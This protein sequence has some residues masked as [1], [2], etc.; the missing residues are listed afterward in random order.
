MRGIAKQQKKQRGQR[1]GR[2]ARG[3][4]RRSDGLRRRGEPRPPQIDIDQVDPSE[5]ATLP[6]FAVNVLSQLHDQ[7]A[8]IQGI[9]LP[10]LDP[11]LQRR[12]LIMVQSHLR[13][14]P[15]LAAGVASL[16]SISQAFA[17]TQATWRFL[18]NE[19]VG[20]TDL[21]EPLREVGRS[22]VG[23]L[24]SRFALLVHDWCK[25]TFTYG[26]R[27]MTQLTHATDVGYELTTA[28]LVSA[29]DGSPLAPMEMHLK[30][31]D[32]VISTRDPTPRD[33]PHLDQVLPTMEASRKWNLDKSLLHVI[34]READSVDYFRKWDAEGFKFLVRADDRRVRWSGKSLL[35]SEIGRSLALG[36]AFSK[37]TDEASYQGRAAELWVA[38]T[39]VVLDRPARK[40][41]KGKRFQVAGRPL[42]LRYIVVQL[43][44]W[45]GK[46][47]AQ[48]MLLTNASKSVHAEHLARCYYWRWRIESFFKLLK[49]HGQQLEQWQ[50]ETGA[51][52]A[53]RLLVAAMA[54]VVVWQLQ[55]DDTPQA[56]ELKAILIRLSGRQMKGNRPHTAPALL[57]GLWVLLSMLALLEHYDLDDLRR[58]AAIIP[59]FR[60]T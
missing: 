49:S 25:L 24:K 32:G 33:M 4:R 26:K 15:E 37:V 20:M 39:E 16:P 10:S 60:R 19:R 56:T 41:V 44:N 1:T 8:A 2:T 30:T 11:R 34:D 29:D 42:R 38:E 18:N 50:Q 47:L 5:T 6:V 51:A 43:R 52:I 48:W 12:Y 58:L 35:L 14:A 21:V 22:R 9:V 28:L 36:S 53:R 3:K 17:A 13:S 7:A 40:N 59:F 45:K 27:D 23:E 54:C 55:A 57:A 46:V 31:A